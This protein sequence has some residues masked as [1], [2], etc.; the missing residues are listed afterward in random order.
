METWRVYSISNHLLF[1]LKINLSSSPE[2][3]N[4]ISILKRLRT[5]PPLI[6]YV[7]LWPTEPIKTSIPLADRGSDFTF[8]LRWG[9]S[10]GEF[11]GMKCCHKVVKWELEWVKMSRYLLHLPLCVTLGKSQL[12]SNLSFLF[13]KTKSRPSWE[14][15]TNIKSAGYQWLSLV[16]LATR[17][18]EIRRILVWAQPR[19]IV[20]ETLSKK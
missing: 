1:W 13:Y 16:I 19:Q 3:L 8:L 11:S 15:I 17:E 9:R 4:G 6:I 14:I 20:L 12:L 18:A 7:I 2:A 5:L 10:P